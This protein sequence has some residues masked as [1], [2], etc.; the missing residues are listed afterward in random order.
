MTFVLP[1]PATVVL[2]GSTPKLRFSCPDLTAPLLFNIEISCRFCFSTLSQCPCSHAS[3]PWFSLSVF[4]APLCC[5]LKHENGVCKTGRLTAPGSACRIKEGWL[6]VSS[7]SSLVINKVR[8]PM[9]SLMSLL[10]HFMLCS[11]KHA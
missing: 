4:P 3:C 1:S 10:L 9:Y 5:L 6:Q 7:R 8:Y 2:D 11:V